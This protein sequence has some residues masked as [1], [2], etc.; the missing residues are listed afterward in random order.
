MTGPQV[1]GLIIAIAVVL[2]ACFVGLVL[3][4]VTDLL[5]TLKS[6]LTTL[7]EAALPLLEEAEQAAKTGNA[8]MVKVAAISVNLQA[9][10]DNVNAVAAT[11]N[12]AASGP[13]MKTAKFSYGVRRVIVSRKTPDRAKQ[14]RAELAAERRERRRG[15]GS[16]SASGDTKD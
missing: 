2:G 15:L 8:G 12:A 10:T 16:G 9:V 5:L 7:A 1:I 6:M 11:A 4:R 13:L 3:L 14:V